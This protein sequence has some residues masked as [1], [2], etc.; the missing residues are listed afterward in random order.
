[1]MQHKNIRIYGFIILFIILSVA[2]SPA[3]DIEEVA[4]TREVVVTVES[5]PVAVE[6]T[7]V[8][9]EAEVVEVTATPMAET[10]VDS[11]D[12]TKDLTICTSE[13]D[14]LCLHNSTG[15]VTLHAIYTNNYTTLSFDYQTEGLEK[16]PIDLQR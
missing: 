14:T 11:I 7:R 10:A 2:C 16:L 6:V 5:E 1:M 15:L 8:V 4:V 13:P 12:I 9:T 3:P